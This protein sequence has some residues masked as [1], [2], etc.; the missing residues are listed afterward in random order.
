MRPA[1]EGGV[2]GHLLQVDAAELAQDEAVGHE[3][4]DLRVAPVVEP[5]DDEQ[6]QDDPDRGTGPPQRQAVRPAP[7]HVGFDPAKDRV[8]LEQPIQLRELGF[9]GPRQPRHESEQ[10]HRR[11]AI[12]D[13]GS[14]SRDLRIR[15]PPL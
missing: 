7:R 14:S 12:D 11:V 15:K 3:V 5:L 10:P 1:Q 13:H 2:V 6:A 9:E 8:I 4:L